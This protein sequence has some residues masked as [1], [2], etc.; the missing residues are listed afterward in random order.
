MKRRVSDVALMP[1]FRGWLFLLDWERGSYDDFGDTPVDA[2]ADTGE[3]SS[4]RILSVEDLLA[5]GEDE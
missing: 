4:D 3:P 1:G 2:A 5:F